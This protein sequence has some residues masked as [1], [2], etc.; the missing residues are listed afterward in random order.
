MGRARGR[1]AVRA[2][3]P[4][5]RSS[6]QERTASCWRRR[7]EPGERRLLAAMPL[8]AITALHG[9]T[10]LRERLAI[11]TEAFPAADRDRIT[12]ALDLASRLH[13]RDRR[14][15]EP[16]INHYAGL[17]IMPTRVAK[18]LVAAA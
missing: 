8:H 3:P 10:G 18:P 6:G 1:P 13:A 15:R 16:Y 5:V 11:E 7:R 4:S 9:E 17:G 2:R 12:R 14:Q